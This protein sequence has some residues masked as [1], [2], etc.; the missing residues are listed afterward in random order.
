MLL[1][2]P[3]DGERRTWE[4]MVR[5]ARKLRTG[6]RL[7]DADGARAGRD[8]RRTAAGDTLTV[9]LVGDGDPLAL[10]QRHGEMPLPPYITD[11]P[12]RARPLPDRVRRR[13]RLGRGADR[14]PALHPR[15][16]GGAGERGCRDRHGSSW[17]SGLDTFKPVTR[18]RPARPRDAQRALPRAGR[19]AAS[20]AAQARRVVAVGTT[21]VRALEIGGDARRA[22]RA[23]RGCSSTGPYDWQVVDVLMTNFHLPRTTLLMMIDAFV[24]ARWR[25][26]YDVALAEGYRF[27]CFGDAMLLDRRASVDAPRPLRDDGHRRRG[28]RRRCPHR[29]RDATARRASCRSA[30]AARSST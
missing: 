2:E 21:S 29:T 5:P 19:R 8:R 26:L 17:W 1:L 18:R 4:A 28:P 7:V 13:A 30:P 3:L 16:A 20:S 12:R 10:L 14:R 24:G 15:A 27:L 6:E 25:R 11:R 22:A 23:A 9:T